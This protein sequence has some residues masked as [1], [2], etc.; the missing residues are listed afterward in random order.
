LAYNFLGMI[1]ALVALRIVMSD[2]PT[3]T[4]LMGR[5]KTRGVRVRVV[6]P[7]PIQQRGVVLLVVSLNSQRFPETLPQIVSSCLRGEVRALAPGEWAL[8]Y[9]Y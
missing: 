4:R 7:T 9:D 2:G 1:D 8:L 6:A 5:S 3:A